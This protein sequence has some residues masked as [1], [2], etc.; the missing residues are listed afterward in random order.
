VNGGDWRRIEKPE[1]GYALRVPMDW[2]E[3]SPNLKNSPWET[4]R[5][6]DPADRQH[7]GV[8]RMPTRP[9]TG[10]AEVAEEAK[11]AL[12]MEGFAEFGQREITFAGRPGVELRFPRRDKRRTWVVREHFVVEGNIAVCLAIAA[13]IPEPDAAFLAAIAQGFEL[14]PAN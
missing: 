3:C 14:L 11:A 6:I 13:M 9:G 2:E 12:E 10:P 8:F 1:Y 4:A 5:F 7:C